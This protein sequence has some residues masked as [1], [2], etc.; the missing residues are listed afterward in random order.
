MKIQV[1]YE[2]P[3]GEYCWLYKPPYSICGH[4]SNESRIPHCELFDERLE[5]DEIGVQKIEKCLE[6]SRRAQSESDR[7]QKGMDQRVEE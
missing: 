2:V 4:F 3:D 1:E 7:V 6:L 5:E